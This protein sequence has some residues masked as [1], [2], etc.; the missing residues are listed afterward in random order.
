M[1]LHNGLIAR[2]FLRGRP[3]SD[4]RQFWNSNFR[5]LQEALRAQRRGGRKGG[6]LVHNDLLSAGEV[7]IAPSERHWLSLVVPARGILEQFS[8]QTGVPSG[9]CTLEELSLTDTALAETIAH[10]IQCLFAMTVREAWLAARDENIPFDHEF[11]RN[12]S[13]VFDAINELLSLLQTRGLVESFFIDIERTSVKIRTVEEASGNRDASAYLPL[14]LVNTWESPAAEAVAVNSQV[15]DV[16]QTDFIFVPGN[17]RLPV[18]VYRA[19]LETAVAAVIAKER[20]AGQ[21]FSFDRKRTF[22]EAYGLGLYLPSAQPRIGERGNPEPPNY[23]WGVVT[24]QNKKVTQFVGFAAH[25]VAGD[26]IMRPIG[27]ALHSYGYSIRTVF[28]ARYIYGDRISK[29]REILEALR[30]AQTIILITHGNP[31]GSTPLFCFES[32]RYGHNCCEQM[33]RMAGALG[34]PTDGIECGLFDFDTRTPDGMLFIEDSGDADCTGYLGSILNPFVPQEHLTHR[35]IVQVSREIYSILG[36]KA[37]VFTPQCYGGGYCP[38][39]SGEVMDYWAGSQEVNYV[40]PILC[41]TEITARDIK[42]E[43]IDHLWCNAQAPS[44]PSGPFCVGAPPADSIIGLGLRTVQGS[45]EQRGAWYPP[46]QPLV[47]C[48]NEH[49]DDNGLQQYNVASI[50][51]RIETQV[52][53][54]PAVAYV[55]WD[56]RSGSFSAGFTSESTAEGNVSVEF[57]DC[58]ARVDAQ[59]RFLEGMS[60]HITPYSAEFQLNAA[61]FSLMSPEEWFSDPQYLAFRHGHTQADWPSYIRVR[62]NGVKAPNGVALVGNPHSKP[63]KWV[64]ADGVQT[65]FV[66]PWQTGSGQGSA[67]STFEVRLPCVPVYTCIYDNFTIVPCG[68]THVT[69]GKWVTGG[70]AYN[71]QNAGCV[72]Y[73]PDA[74]DVPVW[75]EIRR[76]AEPCDGVLCEGTIITGQTACTPCNGCNLECTCE[77]SSPDFADQY[78]NWS[79]GHANQAAARTGMS[80]CPCIWG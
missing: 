51:G 28:G 57:V 70:A 66:P 53:F 36:P 21:T 44:N 1:A 48:R 4:A 23:S 20:E 6:L 39:V 61:N 58:P 49:R 67:G 27:A 29:L 68:E 26:R 71:A 13:G 65:Y 69:N 17:Y 60:P 78:F 62:I 11:V 8:P 76:W 50:Q 25:P 10:N 5:L 3:I 41:D 52:E 75:G 33:R 72:A 31:D 37:A 74:P 7:T 30:E 55:G 34:L 14:L 77:M 2:G 73:N 40:S 80:S 9:A 24:P 63:R 47:Q 19:E 35:C 59:P 45:V 15:Q 16:T 12:R 46:N 42:G 54:A 18:P 22:I 38:T 79:F 64:W 43:S 32:I 56:P